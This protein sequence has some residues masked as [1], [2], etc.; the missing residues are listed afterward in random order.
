MEDSFIQKDI[1]IIHIFIHLLALFNQ[2]LPSLHRYNSNHYNSLY[3]SLHRYNSS[4]S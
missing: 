3:L 2:N 1:P 4:T